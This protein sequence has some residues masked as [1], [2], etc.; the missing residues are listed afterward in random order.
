MKCDH[1]LQM[2]DT[3]RETNELD[4][5]KINPQWVSESDMEVVLLVD[6]RENYARYL[7]LLSRRYHVYIR[8]HF[9]LPFLY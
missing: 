8:I 6:N 9:L 2:Y 5:P 7:Y 4:I 1:F 3:W